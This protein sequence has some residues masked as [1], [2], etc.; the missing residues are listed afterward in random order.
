MKWNNMKRRG[1]RKKERMM[2]VDYFV[3]G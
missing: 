3:Q 2:L 1:R